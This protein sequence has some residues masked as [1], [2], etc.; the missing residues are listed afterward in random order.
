MISLVETPQL[1]IDPGHKKMCTVGV[2]QGL[3]L[4]KLV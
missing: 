3:G 1:E 2:P 4:E